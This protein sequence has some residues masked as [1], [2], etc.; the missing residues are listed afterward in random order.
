MRYFIAIVLLVLPLNAFAYLDPGTSS[1]IIQGLIAA[2]ASVATGIGLFW[3]KIKKMFGMRDNIDEL[4]DE[5]LDKADSSTTH[6]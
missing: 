3:H 5:E 2:I 6:K 4:S 1:L